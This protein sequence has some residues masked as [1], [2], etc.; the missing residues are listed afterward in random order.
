M[1]K[2]KNNISEIC[3][4]YIIKA[5][6]GNVCN[7]LKIKAAYSSKMLILVY[8]TTFYHF[9]GVRDLKMLPYFIHYFFMKQH[10]EF[11]IFVNICSNSFVRDGKLCLQPTLTRDVLGE[12]VL[13]N[14]ILSLR[15]STLSAE[16]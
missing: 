16:E 11:Q 5:E 14:G 3:C 4:I 8:Q 10:S 9:P 15:G 7:L 6:V 2:L 1:V 12:E 13:Y